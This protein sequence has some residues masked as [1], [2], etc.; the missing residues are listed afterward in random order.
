[1]ALQVMTVFDTTSAGLFPYKFK[2]K[3][4]IGNN[5]EEPKEVQLVM[6]VGGK[7]TG[8]FRYPKVYE[9]VLVDD[10]GGRPPQYYL[11]GYL[12]SE[13][14]KSNNFLTNDE[15][16]RKDFANENAFKEAK[17]KFEKEQKDLKDEEGMVLRYKQTGKDAPSTTDAADHFS[18]IG[19][20]HR[21]T[22]WSSTN[23]QYKDINTLPQ[24]GEK[25]TDLAYSNKLVTE[26]FSKATPDEL[27]ADHIRRVT[28]PAI[29]QINIQSTGDIHTTAQ[30]HQQLKAKRFEILVNCS[31]D[32]IHNKAELSKDEL[33]LGDNIGDDSV[34]H[35][36]DAH[37]RAANRVVIKAG[38]EIV[39]QVGKT[40]V[41]ISDD[42]FEVKSKIV[43][44]NF[45]NAYDATFNMSGK[46]GV[47]MFGRGV[48]INADKS[49]GLGDTYGGSVSSDLGVVS[50][51]GREIKAEVYDAVQYAFLTVYAAAQYAQSISSGSMA[52]DG[53]VTHYQVADYIKFAADTLKDGVE[54]ARNFYEVYKDWKEF[55]KEKAD[56]EKEEADP[57]A[58]AEKAKEA[59]EATKKAKDEAG[60]AKEA[61][62]TADAAKTT[63]DNEAEK[64]KDAFEKA[65]QKFENEPTDENKNKVDET[66]KAKNKAESEAKEA[67]TN[68]DNKNE[69]NI[70]ASK[71]YTE[72][73]EQSDAARAKANASLKATE[74]NAEGK[75]T[76]AKE[77]MDEWK[78]A[79]EV[80]KAKQTPENEQLLK[81]AEENANRA[82]DESRKAQA[83]KATVKAHHE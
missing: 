62:D 69:A 54:L 14:D 64:A 24:R 61:F 6:P 12:P 39:L 57:V 55:K 42:G 67:K 9:K 45:T 19:F 77:A 29:D 25:E 7:E 71:E 47:S 40:V 4:A 17:D 32:T 79:R 83:Y 49:F 75:E 33:P 53:S 28:T 58:Q 22:Q 36:G 51:G 70:A 59:E 66:F 3:K 15:P 8:L 16:Q 38:K 52:L 81:N 48:N 10:D 68:L 26:G 44:S 43:N 63:A 76:A 35:K 1:M 74:R 13:E 11:M 78:K 30:N 5:S 41:K 65:K 20:Y 27:P 80:Y 46:D 31:K 60:K 50:I 2:A 34:L 23:S 72:K 73:K 82:L 37:I 21:Q 56:R 18:E